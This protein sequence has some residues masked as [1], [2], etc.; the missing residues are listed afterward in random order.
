M[1]SRIVVGMS[2]G[3]DSSV[4]AYLLKKAGHEVIGIFMKNWEEQDPESGH[5]TAQKDYED[6]RK[7]CDQLDIPCY[8]IEFVDEYRER[9]FSFFLDQYKKGHTPNPDIL[10]N[11][12][13]KFDLFLKKALSLGASHLATG[14][15]CQNRQ[16]SE[17]FYSLIKGNDSQKDQSYFVY[18][19]GQEILSKVVFPIGN[20]KKGEV[21]KIAE[22]AGLP[23]HDKKDSTGICF[24]GERKFREFLSQFIAFKPGEFSL[25]DGTTVGE[26]QGCA[27]YT[28]GQRRG[29]GLG[30][31]GDRW[32][33]VAKDVKTNKVY[34][35]R[36]GDHP[37][38]Y[39]DELTAVDLSWVQPEGE[40]VKK[41][42]NE[43]SYRCQAKVRYRQF[44]QHCILKLLDN[45]QIKA[46]FDQPQRAITPSQAIVFYQGQE[47]LGGGMIESVGESYFERGKGLP[48]GAPFPDSFEALS[49]SVE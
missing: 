2:G 49:R 44:D 30:G 27:F 15:Y 42:M 41:L 20:L 24:I 14:H 38:L 6:V 25:L 31:P 26:H 39:A 37:A 47:C 1:K 12:E 33:V 16:N 17:G 40:A 9:V 28:L 45:G 19:V 35:E 3:V 48:I 18:T 21:R 8:A 23:V 36:G 4:S 29:L 10:C 32:Y 43:G 22:E 7:V 13:I 34:V 5:C 46:E 11:R